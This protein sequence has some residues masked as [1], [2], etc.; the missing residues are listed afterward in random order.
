MDSH[1][2]KVRGWGTARRRKREEDVLNYFKKN[3]VTWAA[4][5]HRLCEYYSITVH[6][7]C[8]AEFHTSGYDCFFR[9]NKKK[10][11]P[12]HYGIKCFHSIQVRVAVV[13]SNCKNS[14]HQRCDANSPPWGCKLCDIL[15]FVTTWVKALHGTQR[16][17]VIEATCKESPYTEMW[18]LPVVVIAQMCIAGLFLA[19]SGLEPQSTFLTKSQ[20]CLK[21]NATA[22]SAVNKLLQYIQNKPLL[23][24]KGGNKSLNKT[25]FSNAFPL[26]VGQ[27]NFL[28]PGYHSFVQVCPR[29]AF[30]SCTRAR[31]T[32][33]LC[34]TQCPW[35]TYQQH[36]G[37]RGAHWRRC[38]LFAGPSLSLPSTCPNGDRISPRWKETLCRHCHPQRRRGSEKVAQGKIV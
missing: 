32:G 29:C 2:M 28:F 17:V 26:F 12:I 10:E 23:K 31:H 6:C 19:C 35:P 14:A 7:F 5:P 16:R 20:S 38:R 33:Q 36:T 4:L 21:I 22:L 18:P 30:F 3:L 27:C 13:T 1:W 25:D 15:P 8:Y 9:P 11:L 37:N 24:T 34:P